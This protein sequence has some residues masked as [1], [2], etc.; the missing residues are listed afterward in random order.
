MTR[1]QLLLAVDETDAGQAAVDFTIGFTTLSD[2]HVTVLHVH[3]LPAALRGPPLETIDHARSLVEE[4]VARLNQAGVAADGIIYSARE[5][6]VARCILETAD[7]RWCTGIV[8]G[9]FRLRGIRR[10][11]G[12]KVRE[13]VTR[14][15]TLPVIVAPP[16]LDPS[17][18]DWPTG[19][20]HIGAS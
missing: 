19:L 15:S 10:L 17:V 11:S 3:E 4:S 1:H 20:D 7:E 8:L 14:R 16:A 18:A 6:T 12:R 5:S 13:Q 9:S 2:T